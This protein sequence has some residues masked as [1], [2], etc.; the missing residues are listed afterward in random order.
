[1]S[2]DSQ[3]SMECIYVCMYVITNNW[4][5]SQWPRGLRR[6]SKAA[7]LL[8]S[9]IW[10]P[11]GVWMSVCCECCVLSGSGLCD[12]L[13]TCPEGS[14]RLWCVVCDLEKQTSWMRR[15]RPTR[16]LSSQEK[17]IITDVKRDYT[18][19]VVSSH[20]QI[21]CRSFHWISYLYSFMFQNNTAVCIK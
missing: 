3:G 5:R 4:C 11:P 8:R 19:K 2:C 20:C 15:P 14:Y 9:W 6:R 16:G 12:E 18:Y 21:N 13:I 17:K 7:R 10:I 1:M